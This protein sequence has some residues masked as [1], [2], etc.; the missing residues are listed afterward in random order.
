MLPVGLAFDDVFFF[1]CFF[2][3]VFFGAIA[4]LSLKVFFVR[5]EVEVF[6]FVGLLFFVFLLEGMAAVYRR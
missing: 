1:D 4:F 3:A 6:D 2:L 5:F